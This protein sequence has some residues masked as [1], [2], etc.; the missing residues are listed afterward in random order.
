M[1]RNQLQDNGLTPVPDQISARLSEFT[2]NELLLGIPAKVIKVSDYKNLQ[3]VDVQ[4]PIKFLYDDGSIMPSPL[5]QKIFV[6]LV[7]GGGFSIK[8]PLAIGD[9]VILK[10][11]HEY[12]GSYLDSVNGTVIQPKESYA[13]ERD[14]WVEPG[15][16]TRKTHQSPSQTD[17][18]IEGPNTTIT[19]TPA[20]NVTVNTAGTSYLK[21]SHHTIDTDSTINGN[22]D[23]NGTLNVSDTVTT[24]TVAAGV[25]GAT[26]SLTVDGASVLG[27]DHDGQVPPFA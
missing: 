27:H 1:S 23:I 25:V 22:V 12:L 18:V 8:V 17:L 20:G 4:S 21:S 9:P 5:F 15:F 13:T 7:A 14:C 2:K 6:R 3:C 10:Y 16:G 26:T 11:S 24:P 19:I